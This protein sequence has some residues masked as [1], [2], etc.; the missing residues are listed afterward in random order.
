VDALPDWLIALPDAQ[1]MRA[2]D[3]WAIERSQ[4]GQGGAAALELMERAGAAVARA[5]EGHCADGPVAV[6]CGKGNNG[7]DGLVAARH[8]REAGREVAV[9]CAAP[10]DELS[11]DAREN[12]RRL[13][14][15]APVSLADGMQA[16]AEAAAAVDALLGTGL[17]GEPH[18]EIATAI[19]ALNTAAAPVVAVDVPSGVDA[20]TGVVLAGAVR[21]AVTVTFHAAKPGLWI[22]PGKA[23]AGEVHVVDIGIPRG[24]PSSATIGLIAN[25]VR[26]RLPRR[27]AESTKFA[28]GQVLV[29]GG[30]RGLAGAPRM[31]SRASMRAGA[32]YVIA[33]VPRS[34]QDAIAGADT[35]ELM[36]R[37]LAEEDGALAASAVATVLE[38]IRPGGAL[39]LG[40]GLGRT[41]AAV[42]FAREL[43]R[44]ADA[45]MVLDADGLNAHAGR[46]GDLAARGRATVLTPHAGELGRLLE[47]DSKQIERERLRH[48]R[49][50]AEQARAVVV[51]KGDDTLIAAAD[52]HVAVSQGGTAALAT[53]GTGD[54]LTGV[55][56]A[57]L[58]QRL[59][60][61]TAACAGVWLHAESGR[62]AARRQGSVEGVI[63]SDVIESLPAARRGGDA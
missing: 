13:P 20:S 49:A 26:E 44:Q 16:I 12:L 42:S 29:A 4:I 10:L 41:D 33:C 9:V 30:S 1:T 57:L 25:S 28:S 62:E 17:A 43:A 48:V 37:G 24:A 18:G 35:P 51:L 34:L 40:P 45:P 31:A 36:T 21:A 50:A 61:F 2:I 53:A 47:I 56:A 32:G 5:V 52:G 39:A 7:G 46:L 22:R 3:R 59:D 14:G 63:A 15:D 11:G 23:Y 6:V 27:G 8:L 55:I 54:V 38:N 19:E 60:P 58:A